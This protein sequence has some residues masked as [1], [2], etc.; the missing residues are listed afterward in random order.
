MSGAVREALLGIRTVAE[1]VE[2]FGDEERCRRLLEAMIWPHGR[3]LS[4]LWLQALGSRWRGA[5]WA[6]TARG[7]VHANSAEGFNLRV[8]R[9]VAGVF[10]HISPRACRLLFP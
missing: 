7:R 10:H 6:D 4:G 3:G 1:M 2:A 5:T 8:R 9:T